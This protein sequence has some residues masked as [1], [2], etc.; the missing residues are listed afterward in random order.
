MK[1]SVKKMN[2]NCEIYVKRVMNNI[3]FYFLS[4]LIQQLKDLKF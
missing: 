4:L 3:Y 2:K 1:I